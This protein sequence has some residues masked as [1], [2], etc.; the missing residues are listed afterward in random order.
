MQTEFWGRPRGST[1]KRASSSSGRRP[2]R[3]PR[4]PCKGQEAVLLQLCKSQPGRRPRREAGPLPGGD[5]EISLQ[6]VEAA[7]P[8]RSLGRRVPGAGLPAVTR[9]PTRLGRG[10]PGPA[11]RPPPPGPAAPPE[12]PGRPPLTWAAA[13]RRARRTRRTRTRRSFVSGL[14]CRARAARSPSARGPP[15]GA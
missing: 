14:P 2:R 5:P 1:P 3:V 6:G 7:A 15:G 11:P 10:R 8:H 4:P 13:A 9:K 12:P